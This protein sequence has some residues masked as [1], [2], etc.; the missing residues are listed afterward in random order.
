MHDQ[1]IQNVRYKL[2]KRAR[3]VNSA[4]SHLFYRFVKHFLQFV[5]STPIL[6]AI[7]D[8]MLARAE[9]LE[10]E[11][12]V[13]K[14][15][16]GTA[17][18][19]DTEFESVAL[20]YVILNKAMFEKDT[21]NFLDMSHKFGQGVDFDAAFEFARTTFFEPFYEYLDE[22]IDDRQAVLKVLRDYKHRSEWFRVEQLVELTEDTKRGEKRLASDLYEY[23]HSCGIDIH[24][25]P[26]SASGIPDFI[27]DQSSDNRIVADAKLF[28]PEKQKSKTYLV[29]GF[30]QVYTYLREFNEAV[31]Y[32]VIFKMCNDGLNLLFPPTNSLFPHITVNNKTVF[33]CVIDLANRGVPASKRGKLKHYDIAEEDFYESVSDNGSTSEKD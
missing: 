28:W 25:E 21:V 29:S 19:C 26:K 1:Y 5:D 23:L 6:A 30:N 12:F 15:I 18:Q 8:D 24:I 7:R 4:E 33:F 9:E 13:E 17:L 11:T 16:A 22:N 32:L 2:Q 10:L 27:A 14:A 3:R 20:G 31:G